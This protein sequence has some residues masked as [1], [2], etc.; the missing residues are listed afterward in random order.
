MSFFIVYIHRPDPA[1]LILTF[2]ASVSKKDTANGNM[3][4]HWACTSGNYAVV[5]I[6][7]DAGA[8]PMAPNAKVCI[9]TLVS[10][11]VVM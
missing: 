6:L 10:V 9:F 7:A 2:G 4:L 3:A 11:I 5:R 8:D 1:R